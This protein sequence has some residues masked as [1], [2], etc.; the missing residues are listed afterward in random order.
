MHDTPRMHDVVEVDEANFAAEVEQSDIPVFVDFWA[1]WCG[2]CKA[3]AP[4]FDKLAEIYGGRIKFAKVNTDENKALAERMDV[5]G[6]PT[7]LLIQNG[8]VVERTSGSQSKSHFSNL[9]D[10]YATAP[11]TPPTPAAPRRSFRAFY[12]DAAL[13]DAVVERVG[14]HINNDRILSCGANGPLSDPEHQRY[15]LM[16]A[17]LESADV[18]RYEGTLG[19][20]ANAARVAELVHGVSMREVDVD[21]HPQYHLRG[22]SRL[23]PLEWLLA[24]PLGADLGT[25][26]PRF[27]HWYLTDIVSSTFL[28]QASASPEAHTVAE[29]VAF[30]HQRQATGDPPTAAQWKQARV[31][32]GEALARTPV[33]GGK[34]D[35]FSHLVMTAAEMLAWPA[36]ELEEALAGAIGTMFYA[37]WQHAL[38]LTYP[39]EEWAHRLALLKAA[40]DREAAS[41]DASPEQMETFEEVKAFRALMQDCQARD[42]AVGLEAKYAFGER[43]H[44]GLMQVLAE[45]VEVRA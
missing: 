7:L 33:Q 40:Q 12:G 17:A 2:P 34:P 27:I 29:R 4:L 20:P 11:V 23:Y 19:I 37:L 44:T 14:N 39:A 35:V 45:T 41:P 26:A 25:L 24:I 31:A 9:L 3:L 32:A 28:Y 5:R 8:Q 38:P 42:N 15:S 36:E 22:V 13:R 18:Q 30:L 21:G 16:A 43:L 10:K 1:P 6:L